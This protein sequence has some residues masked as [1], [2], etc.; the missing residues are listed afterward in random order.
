MMDY[1][2]IV[3]IGGR[4]LFAFLFKPVYLMTSVVCLLSFFLLSFF[5]PLSG[6]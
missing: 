1:L 4:V 3:T 2:I 5:V 6:R